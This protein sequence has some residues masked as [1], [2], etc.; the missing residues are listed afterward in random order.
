[1]RLELINENMGNDVYLMYQDIDKEELGSTNIMFGLS[2]L[3]Y[4]TE[5]NNYMSI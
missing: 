1:M 3:E 2:Y 5:Y 4:Q